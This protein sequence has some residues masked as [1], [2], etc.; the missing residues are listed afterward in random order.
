MRR[1]IEG[2]DDDYEAQ[3]RAAATAYIR[4]ATRDAALLELMYAAKRGEQ[5]AALRDAFGSPV[6]RGRRPDPPGTAG[7][8]QPGDPNRVRLLLFATMQGIAAL[9][10]SGSVDAGQTDGLIAD[11]GRALHAR[12]ALTASGPPSPR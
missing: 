8:L 1:R 12:P 6:H 7:Q 4:F 9:V 2:A 3:L 10:T 11:A 5:S